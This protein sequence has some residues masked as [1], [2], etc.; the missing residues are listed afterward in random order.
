MDGDRNT[1]SLVEPPITQ[2]PSSAGPLYDMRHMGETGSR[3]ET[4]RKKRE[5]VAPGAKI[6]ALDEILKTDLY[7]AD[8]KWS[9]FITAAHSYRFDTCLHPFPPQ[10]Y[11][12][13]FKDISGLVSILVCT[14]TCMK[15]N[16]YLLNWQIFFQRETLACVPSFQTL[17]HVLQE[18][19]VYE[20][21]A[22][23]ID[24]LYWVLVEVREPTIRTVPKSQVGFSQ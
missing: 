18:P 6:Q 14:Y 17:L 24:L 1:N 13:G 22:A 9:L 3:I 7:A 16:F 5:I 8:F 15:S 2:G 4:V 19:E 10:Y 21:R 11:K 20:S 23:A 12:D